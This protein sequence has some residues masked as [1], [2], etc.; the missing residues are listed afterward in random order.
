MR[1]ISIAATESRRDLLG[2]LT[3][4]VLLPHLSSKSRRDHAAMVSFHLFGKTHNEYSL[5]APIDGNFRTRRPCGAC[6]ARLAC[7]SGPESAVRTPFVT[8]RIK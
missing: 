1:F 5:C 2:P 6:A 4:S 8:I 7:N 3:W